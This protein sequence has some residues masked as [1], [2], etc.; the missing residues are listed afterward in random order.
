MESEKRQL[1]ATYATFS[2][3]CPDEDFQLLRELLAYDSLCPTSCVFK[4]AGLDSVVYANVP[5]PLH[6]SRQREWPW[7]L[8]EGDFQPWHRCLDIGS[9]WSVLKFALAKRTAWVDCLEINPEFIEKAKPA[10]DIIG[11]NNITQTQGDMA[12]IPFE[13]NTF[14]RLCS[15]S[16]MEHSNPD[17]YVDC[18]KE[19]K[20]VLRPGGIALLTMDVVVFG[21]PK[22]DFHMNLQNATPVL[23]EL[24]INRISDMGDIVKA[25]IGDGG[26]PNE[27][28]I[29]VMMIRWEKPK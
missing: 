18:I 20:R 23:L 2:G 29:V 11:M 1:P 24:G 14:D 7:I 26:K 17:K 19:V 10:I 12:C 16:V 22:D 3:N 25:R 13:D 4:R 21:E 15:C 6:W 28:H 27:I 5:S 8:R 9:G